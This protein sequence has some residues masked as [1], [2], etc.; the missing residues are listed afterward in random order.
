MP[1]RRAD[2]LASALNGRPRRVRGLAAF[3]AVAIVTSAAMALRG[4]PEAQGAPA[5]PSIVLISTDDQ[6][7]ASLRF[8]R[9]TNSLLVDRGTSFVNSFATFPLCCP[10]RA[11]WITGQYAHNNGVIDN[12]ERNGGG[13]D[14]LRDPAR[15]LPAWLKFNGYDTALIGKWL[16]GYESLRPPPGWDRWNGLVPPTVTRYYGYEIADSR[17]GSVTAGEQRSD[18]LTDALTRRYAIPYI[19]SRAG[20][21]DPFFL[22]LSYTSPHWGKGRNDLSGRRCANGRPFSFAT[23][24]AKPAARHAGKFAAEPLPQG[25]AFNEPSLADKPGGVRGRPRL[26]RRQVAELTRR[27]RCSL[28]ALLSVDEGVKQIDA[29]LEATGLA[30]N[31]YVIFTSDNGYMNG[32][33]RISAEK[34]QPYEEAI[35]VPMVIRGPGIPAGARLADPVANV[36]LAPTI[37]DIA[38]A[39][40]PPL[41]GRPIDGISMLPYLRGFTHPERA[42]LIEAK[43]PPRVTGSGRILAPSWVGVR[44]RRYTYVE[45]YREE[46]PSLQQGFGRPIGVGQLTDRELYDLTLDP[47]QL[48]SRHRSAAYAAPRAALSAALSRLRACEAEECLLDTSIP[49]PALP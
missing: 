40:Q 26:D 23:A 35:R 39:R 34:V 3:A 29:A 45:H 5:R 42:I 1:R 20:D 25:R 4:D 7:A 24:R 43:R 47:E 15:V 38:G 48:R 44:T 37:M 30:A 11:T 46:V 6:T 16:H 28:A 49:P 12:Q 33:H 13:Y 21:P 8:M 18:Y 32:E 2:R 22:H 14:A 10:A 9:R 17:G 36:D 27:Y 31:T 19:Y 41:V